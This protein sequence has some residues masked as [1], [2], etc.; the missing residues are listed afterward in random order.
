MQELDNKAR[1]NGFD[2]EIDLREIFFALFKGR[3]T[4]FNSTA[5]LLT[6][7]IIYCLLLPNIYKSESLLAP[8]DDSSS[9][10]NSLGDYSSLAGLVG[11]NLPEGESDGNSKKHLK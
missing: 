4:I 8:V 9:L 10:L 6:I 2:D 5:L 11:I 3:W 1:E 7:G